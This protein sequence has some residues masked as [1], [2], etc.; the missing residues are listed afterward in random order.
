M[1]T[2][3]LF[4]GFWRLLLKHGA[5]SISE[6]YRSLVTRAQV[7]RLQRY[8]PEITVDDVEPAPAGVRAQVHAQRRPV[9]KRENG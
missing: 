2:Q 6:I 7:A 5:F 4:P 1:A 8:I 9:W 3:L